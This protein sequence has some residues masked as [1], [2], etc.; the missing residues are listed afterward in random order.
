MFGAGEPRTPER[1]MVRNLA[2]AI[3]RVATALLMAACLRVALT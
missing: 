2:E 3:G 1:M